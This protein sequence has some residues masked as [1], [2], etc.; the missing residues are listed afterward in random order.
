MLNIGKT[1]IGKKWNDVGNERG[2]EKII[3]L[4]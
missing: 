2:K 3:K 4:F 1:D